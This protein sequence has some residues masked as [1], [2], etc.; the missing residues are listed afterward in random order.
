M[1]PFLYSVTFKK[2]PGGQPD[3]PWGILKHQ[4]I[5]SES[6]DTNL[7][8]LDG[9]DLT[10]S[11]NASKRLEWDHPYEKDGEVYKAEARPDL[12]D[13]TLAGLRIALDNLTD[14]WE[15]SFMAPYIRGLLGAEEERIK[16]NAA[17]AAA[18]EDDDA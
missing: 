2:G 1:N 16:S 18:N 15:I 10:R 8:Y 6:H 4:G 11:R 7:L 17:L 14:E 12:T 9:Y 3:V 5:L 13:K